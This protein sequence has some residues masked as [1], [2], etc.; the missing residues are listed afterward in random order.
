MENVEEVVIVGYNSLKESNISGAVSRVDMQVAQKRRVQDIAQM[1]Q[2]QASGVNIT[3][4]TGQPGD[5]IDIRVRGI[6]TIGNNSPLFVVDGIPTT[7]FSF[8]NPADIESMTVLKDASSAAIYGSRAAAGVILITTKSGKVGS[9]K[10]EVNAFTGINS[11]VNLPK[12][13]NTTDYLN[14]LEKAWSNTYTTGTNPYI[15]QKSRTDIANKNWINE[16]FEKGKTN[17]FNYLHLVPPSV[18]LICFQVDTMDRT[19]LL[20]MTMIGID[21]LSSVQM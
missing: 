13:M 8:V 20:F 21:V 10:F 14:T 2:G 17:S 6:G 15:S 18:Y 16:L 5:A 1:L 3:Q 9:A 19:V 11:A 7:N 12:M 4:S